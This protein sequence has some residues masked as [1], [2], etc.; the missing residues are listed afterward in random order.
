MSSGSINTHAF[1]SFDAR[2]SNFG[3]N[4]GHTK[5]FIAKKNMIF[6]FNRRICRDGQKTHQN[7]LYI[8]KMW[9]EGIYS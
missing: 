3:H 8:L 7:T 1:Y 9:R 6:G 2:K 5:V 4:V